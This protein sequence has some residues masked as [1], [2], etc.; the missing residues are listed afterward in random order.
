MQS[1]RE[2]FGDW[3]REW[4]GLMGCAAFT[5]LGIYIAATNKS[6][7]WIVGGSA[8]LGT[9]LFFVASYRAWK[10]LYDRLEAAQLEKELELARNNQR[11]RLVTALRTLHPKPHQSV[12]LCYHTGFPQG[13]AIASRLTSLL[14]EAGWRVDGE[15]HPTMTPNSNGVWVCRSTTAIRAHTIAILISQGFDA[16]EENVVRMDGEDRPL[17]ITVC[18][19]PFLAGEVVL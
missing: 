5:F 10:K 14:V 3:L 17:E 15:V 11:Q 18:A 9:I 1:V 7:A 2:F 19:E 6:N 16:H 4:W 8:A 13:R 12:T